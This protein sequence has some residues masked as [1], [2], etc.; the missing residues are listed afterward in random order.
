MATTNPG[1]NTISVYSEKLEVGYRYYQAHGIKPAFAF[2]HGAM[3][4]STRWI[5]ALYVLSF[6]YDDN[7]GSDPYECAYARCIQLC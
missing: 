7:T 2:G 4:L 5:R 1:V 6:F 3:R